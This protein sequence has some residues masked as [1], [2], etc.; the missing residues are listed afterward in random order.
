MDNHKFTA[1]LFKIRKVK[2]Q[3]LIMIQRQSNR[4][5]TS[6]AREVRFM[7]T[8]GFNDR[9]IEGIEGAQPESS[10]K[11]KQPTD[12]DEDM[13]GSKRLFGDGKLQ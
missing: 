11:G 7:S 5:D 10:R 6:T 13:L 8:E 4:G 9:L 12:R 2:S 3:N 1:N